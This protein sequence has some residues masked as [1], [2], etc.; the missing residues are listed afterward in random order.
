[1]TEFEVLAHNDGIG[2]EPPAGSR[3]RA[4]GGVIWS[5]KPLVYFHTKRATKRAVSEA[6]MISPN[7]WPMGGGDRSRPPIPGSALVCQIDMQSTQ[8]YWKD[9]YCLL[10]VWITTTAWFNGFNHFWIHSLMLLFWFADIL[11]LLKP[12]VVFYW[13]LSTKSFSP[14]GP[15][16]MYTP[17]HDEIA[18]HETH[19]RSLN[20]H[21][22]LDIR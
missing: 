1:M 3:D 18:L 9:S 20:L 4:P 5:W 6:A 12:P 15:N 16:N 17:V 13:C 2:V 22:T 11:A 7:F 8:T 19:P 21:L 14:K 10:G